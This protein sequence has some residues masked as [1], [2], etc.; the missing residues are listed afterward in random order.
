MFL[1]SKCR[2][3]QDQN[4]LRDLGLCTFWV[5][6]YP[7]PLSSSDFQKGKKITPLTRPSEPSFIFSLRLSFI[8]TWCG[9]ACVADLS[10]KSCLRR[11]F[12]HTKILSVGHLILVS[13]LVYQF[14]WNAQWFK[15]KYSMIT[16]TLFVKNINEERQRQQLRKTT[17]KDRKT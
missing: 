8:P 4:V 12:L 14:Y 10:Q 1:I 5:L 9:D 6:A 3:V 11:F 7:N 2:G 15:Y 17:K 13:F 16:T